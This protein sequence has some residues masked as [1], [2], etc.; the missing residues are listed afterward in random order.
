[1]PDLTRTFGPDSLHAWLIQAGLAS[2]SVHELFDGFCQ[3]LTAVDFPLTRGYLSTATLHPVLWA[4]GITWQRGR[5]VEE[6]EL[7]YGYERRAAWLTSPFRHMLE[8]GVARLHRK[9]AGEGAMLDFPVLREFREAGLT[10]W[11]GL[12]YGFGWALEHQEVDQLGVIFSWATDCP[13]GWSTEELAIIEELS[14]TLA[15]VVKGSSS[16]N[17]TRDLL[18]TY[19]GDDAAARVVTGQVRRGSV[20]RIKAFILYADLRGFTDF[21]DV[22]APEEV[23]R[24]LNDYCDCM[25]EPVKE[26][27]GQILKFLGDGLLAVFLSDADRDRTKVAAATLTAAR[28]ILARVERLN[29][30][31]AAAGGSPLGIDVALHEGEVTYGNVGTADRLDFTVIGPA[32]NEASRLENLCTELGV[33]LLISDSFVL[34]APA[35]RPQLVSLGR[36][37]LRGVREPREVFTLR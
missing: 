18:A 20:G 24:R 13:D 1:M 14:G 28:D 5:I 37:Q 23:T 7:S 36:H 12:F 22:T 35:M 17:T 16:F 27:G 21:A 10:E 29:A 3:R 32:V 2:L 8:S 11:L 19:L 4:T 25:G 15:L 33:H 34:A 6:T 30:N 26:A 31:E 9:L